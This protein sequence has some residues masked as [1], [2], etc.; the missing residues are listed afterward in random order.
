MEKHNFT[1][2]YVRVQVIDKVD[3]NLNRKVMPSRRYLH[4][5]G[6]E[7]FVAYNKEY[8]V[9]KPCGK[10]MV[11]TAT[12]AK[13]IDETSIKRVSLEDLGIAKTPTKSEP[14]A[15]PS[16][17]K[18]LSL[19][20]VFVEDFPEIPATLAKKPKKQASKKQLQAALKM[21]Y[22]KLQSSKCSAR[23]KAMARKAIKTITSKLE[24]L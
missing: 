21:Q 23:Q 18:A 20:E 11:A 9:C 4:T 17:A 24:E 8:R 14:K 2:N 16:K 6:N 7:F 19:D 12:K 10:D 1:T 13:S 15:K 3:E 5:D 22:G